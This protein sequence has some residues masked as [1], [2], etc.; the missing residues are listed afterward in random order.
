MLD[1]W[2]GFKKR[3]RKVGTD[4]HHSELGRRQCLEHRRDH[5]GGRESPRERGAQP[6]EGGHRAQLNQSDDNPGACTWWKL[7]GRR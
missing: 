3:E 4:T 2:G 1:I 6:R 5:E 7:R